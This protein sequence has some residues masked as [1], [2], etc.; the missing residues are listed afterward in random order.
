MTQARLRPADR[1]ERLPGGGGPGSVVIGY[2]L[3]SIRA[4]TVMS[5]SS[6]NSPA[7]L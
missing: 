6:V 1:R 5:G 2:S 3:N 7:V 4:V